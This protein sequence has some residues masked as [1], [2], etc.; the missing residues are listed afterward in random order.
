MGE[1]E[2]ALPDCEKSIELDPDD[3]NTLDSRARVYQALG[4]IDEAIVDF[5]RIIE[6]GSNPDLSQQ[7]AEELKSIGRPEISQQEPVNADAIAGVWEGSA[8]GGSLT[9]QI[10]ITIE[11]SCGVDSV[12]GPFDIP[13]IP[14]SGTFILINVT[15]DTY[16]FKTA[17][18][19]GPCGV[20]YSDTLTLLPDGTLLYVSTGEYGET[21]EVLQ[22]VK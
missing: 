2:Q 15:D 13:A 14:C 10:T 22:R 6:L 19:Q 8:S 11:S 20:A 21:R 7:A 17:D 16:S 3:V 4:R 18:I 9:F 1:Y 12:C 5:E